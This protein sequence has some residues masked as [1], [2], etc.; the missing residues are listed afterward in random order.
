MQLLRL[1][2]GNGSRS[3]LFGLLPREQVANTNDVIHVFYFIFSLAG[4]L[5][6]VKSVVWKHLIRDLTD[7]RLV[8]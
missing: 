6:K 1:A 2:L 3:H 5:E 7:V 4:A 8:L